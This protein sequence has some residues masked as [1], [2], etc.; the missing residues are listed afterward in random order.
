MK[1][2]FTSLLSA[3]FLFNSDSKAQCSDYSTLHVAAHSLTRE[4][5]NSIEEIA[6]TYTTGNYWYTWNASISSTVTRSGSLL[7]SSSNSVGYGYVAQLEWHDAPSTTGSGTYYMSN[8]HGAQSS[9]GGSTSYSTSD[10]L[11]VNKPYI[12]GGN[13]AWFLG[14]GVSD[15]ANGYY[16][17]ASL[18]ANSNCNAGD[19]CAATPYWTV[20]AGSS[21]VSLSCSSCSAQTLTAIAGSVTGSDIS[22]TISIAGFTSEPFYFSVGT[23]KTVVSSINGT[24][25]S[26]AAFNDGFKSTIYYSTRDNFNNVMP[27]IA[28]NEQFG[29]T[30]ND[31]PNNWANPSAGGISSYGSYEWFDTLSFYSCASVTPVC[32]NPQSPL[33]SSA[34]KHYSQTWRVG[35]S[36][37]GTG[38]IVQTDNLQYYVDHGRHTNIVTPVP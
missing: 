19:T 11:Y 29:S 25:I 13:S 4:A 28:L 17:Q 12:S 6:Q 20:T 2:Y 23:P 3:L 10:T 15:S 8:L 24:P 5:S 21:K 38:V 30:T 1:V 35:S 37:V 22:L 9:C 31:Q 27:S 7:H 14:S 36:T 26:D 18:T 33:S 34:V 16:N 32:T